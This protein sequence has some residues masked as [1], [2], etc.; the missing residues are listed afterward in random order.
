MGLTWKILLDIAFWHVLIHVELR[1]TGKGLTWRSCCVG[2]GPQTL[3]CVC[4][5]H[6]SMSTAALFVSLKLSVPLAQSLGWSLCVQDL[7]TDALLQRICNVCPLIPIS[8]H[9]AC[10][11]KPE[12]SALFS[13]KNCF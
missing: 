12:S 7:T 4:G 2:I 6:P 10:H 8:H 1:V 11:L 9:L 13:N 3:Q 5:S